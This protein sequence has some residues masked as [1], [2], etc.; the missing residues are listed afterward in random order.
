LFSQLQVEV[1]YQPGKSNIIAD[2]LSRIKRKENIIVNAIV[3]EENDN[4]NRNNIVNNGNI[5]NNNPLN[6][7]SE[8]ENEKYIFEFMKIFLNGRVI[9]IDG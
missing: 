2:A 9:T 8:N 7:I 3:D 1:V 6:T 4:S 5:T